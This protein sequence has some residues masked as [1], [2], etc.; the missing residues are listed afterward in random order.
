MCA[1]CY[2]IG[3]PASRVDRGEGGSGGSARK[4]TRP[5]VRM[6]LRRTSQVTTFVERRSSCLARV[7]KSEH[8]EH[9][10]RPVV[11]HG[12]VGPARKAE[13]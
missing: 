2:C 6:A 1:A 7:V 9:V 10:G 5:R 12:D 13:P 3:T 11:G 4:D 8:E